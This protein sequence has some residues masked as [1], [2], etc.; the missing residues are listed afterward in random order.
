MEGLTIEGEVAKKR[1][2]GEGLH[3]FCNAIILIGK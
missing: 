3:L 2:K 1:E